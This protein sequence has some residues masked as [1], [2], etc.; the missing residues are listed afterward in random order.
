MVEIWA[1][2]IPAEDV[3]EGENM[4][5][6]VMEHEVSTRGLIHLQI[7]T[8]YGFYRSWPGLIYLLRSP[9]TTLL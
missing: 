6:S 4:D 5:K 1:L 3:H 9:S 8:G 2:G 7:A